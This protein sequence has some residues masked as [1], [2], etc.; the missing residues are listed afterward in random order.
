[1]Q[2]AKHFLSRVIFQAN[3]SADALK[4]IIDAGLVEV[5]KAQSGV[6]LSEAKSIVVNFHQNKASVTNKTQ[7]NFKGD[8]IHIIVQ[9]DFL[10]VINLRYTNHNDYHPVIGAL[11]DKFKAIYNAKIT[12][13]SLRYI[14]NIRFNEGNTFDFNGLINESLLKPTLEYKHFGLTRS[15]GSMHI[16][17]SEKDLNTTFTY[18]FANSEYPNKIAK[19]EFVLDYD[20][21]Q[22]ITNDVV[23]INPIILKIRNKVNELFEH[24]VL[25][26]LRNKMKEN[27]Q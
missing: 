11:F 13:V 1:M 8:R 4:D 18:G 17:D 14:N 20:C 9:D 23:A 15:M 7:W 16:F 12:R 24:S 21:Y 2:Y 27:G 6:E 25:D 3:Y 26:G 10:Q 22:T 5:C 19:R